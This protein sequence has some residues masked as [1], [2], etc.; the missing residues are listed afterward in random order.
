MDNFVKTNRNYPGRVRADLQ[1]AVE[2]L[3][4]S[5]AIRAI[6]IHQQYGYEQINL[7]TLWTNGRNAHS[8]APLSFTFLIKLSGCSS[9]SSVRKRPK[10]SYISKV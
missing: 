9:D 6:G 1:T 2:E 3:F 7:M 10:S 5:K 4:T 8:I